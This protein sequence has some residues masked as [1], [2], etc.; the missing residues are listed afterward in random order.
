MRLIQWI[1]RQFDDNTSPYSSFLGSVISYFFSSTPQIRSQVLL[2]NF[3]FRI[4]TGVQNYSNLQ[5]RQKSFCKFSQFQIRLQPFILDFGKKTGEN[6]S[7]TSKN[8][9]GIYMRGRM[10]KMETGSRLTHCVGRAQRPLLVWKAYP[11]NSI[12]KASYGWLAWPLGWR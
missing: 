4:L 1:R 7:D 12:R 9:F 3:S 6:A 5:I 11:C 10:S 8:I 2:R